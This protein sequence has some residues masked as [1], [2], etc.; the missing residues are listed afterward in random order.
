MGYGHQSVN[1]FY[2]VEFM[3]LIGLGANVSGTWGAPE[4]TLRRVQEIFEQNQVTVRAFSPIFLTE[5][6]GPSQPVYANAAALVETAMPACTLL[7]KL[8][9]IEAES[10]RNVHQRKYGKR[11]NARPLDLD[12]LTYH[13]IVIHW[14]R[15]EGKISSRS[16]RRL[17]L[18]HPELHNRA[19]VL[20][21]VSEI[22]PAWRHPVFK[23]T[24]KE[25]LKA[26]KYR[27]QG[28]ILD[29][30]PASVN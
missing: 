30:L 8:K 19:F 10:G 1:F 5:P 9:H 13:D 18:P 2:G 22:A 27:R 15:G 17:I 20:K 3:I 21:P 25:M 12:L 29:E 23:Q 7:L 26:V 14:S 24:A 11:W 28:R 6:L 16:V 4:A